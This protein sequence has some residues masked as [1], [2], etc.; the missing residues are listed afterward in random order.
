MQG[1]EKHII[2]KLKWTKIVNSIMSYYGWLKHANCKNLQNKYFNKE[3]CWII[4]YTC[5]EHGINNPLRKVS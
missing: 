1:K 5:K 2:R 4:K 3:I